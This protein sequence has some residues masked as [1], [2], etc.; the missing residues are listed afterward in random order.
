MIKLLSLNDGRAV[1]VSPVFFVENDMA[2][3]FRGLP[4]RGKGFKDKAHDHSHSHVGL[5]KFYR[6]QV[7]GVGIRSI[8]LAGWFACY[9]IPEGV[10]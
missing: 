9:F 10:I 8:R 2:D 3:E 5:G 1:H 6:Y 4:A 7:I